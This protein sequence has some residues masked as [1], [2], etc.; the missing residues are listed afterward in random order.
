MDH[1]DDRDN[2]V[3]LG[4][5]RWEHARWLNGAMAV[6]LFNLSP[7][8]NSF[9]FMGEDNV[10][11]NAFAELGAEGPLVALL[12]Q[13]HRFLRLLD[14]EALLES[15]AAQTRLK[16]AAIIALGKADA[17]EKPPIVKIQIHGEESGRISPS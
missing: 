14:R 4:P 2:W 16:I 6:N 12:D 9:V 11:Q 13:S 1:G 17:E 10:A 15:L 5:D 8:L 3:Q 7:E